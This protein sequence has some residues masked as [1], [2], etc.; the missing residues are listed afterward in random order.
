MINNPL[1]GNHKATAYV[2]Q[3]GES[4]GE[5]E[6]SLD[7]GEKELLELVKAHPRFSTDY[8]VWYLVVCP[9]LEIENEDAFDPK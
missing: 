7:T 5:F 3:N 6:V 9:E 8:L 1:F 4:L 2:S